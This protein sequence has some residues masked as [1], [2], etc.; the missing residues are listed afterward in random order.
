MKSM[1]FVWGGCRDGSVCIWHS[2]SG[3]SLERLFKVHKG[4]VK[5]LLLVNEK[6]VWSISPS[7]GIYSYQPPEVNSNQYPALKCYLQVFSNS[8]W[9][10]RF[11][12]LDN[13]ILSFYKNDED[14]NEVDTVPLGGVQ[15][16][17]DSKRWLTFRLTL[18]NNDSLIFQAANES[19]LMDW[20][21]AIFMSIERLESI[22]KIVVSSLVLWFSLSLSLH[23]LLI[24]SHLL[25]SISFE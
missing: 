11:V 21:V 3:D 18:P 9:K 23:F 14:L 13:G 25:F 19:N 8:K 7:D 6:E 20:T 22:S 1:S 10:R 4:P 5:Q 24:L 2:I 16:R 17:P 12:I 15:I